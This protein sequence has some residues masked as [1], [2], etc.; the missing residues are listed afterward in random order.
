VCAAV[1]A[2]IAVTML[3]TRDL[4]SSALSLIPPDLE[5]VARPGEDARRQDRPVAEPEPAVV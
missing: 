3:R 2:V 5:D 4:H 1:A